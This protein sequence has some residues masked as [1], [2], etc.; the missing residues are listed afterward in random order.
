[1]VEKGRRALL[2][3]SDLVPIEDE[4]TVSRGAGDSYEDS[5]MQQRVPESNEEAYV[6]Q[7]VQFG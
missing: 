7:P 1:M 6:R 4:P 3:R 2:S 5:P